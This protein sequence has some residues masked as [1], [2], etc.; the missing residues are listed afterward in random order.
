ML[1]L[2]L[3]L[4]QSVAACCR[5][6]SHE[7]GR[8]QAASASRQVGRQTGLCG[9]SKPSC[10]HSGKALAQTK[11]CRALPLLVVVALCCGC[12]KVSGSAGRGEEKDRASDQ[13]THQ[14]ADTS[15]WPYTRSSYCLLAMRS[16][17]ASE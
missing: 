2:P 3:L 12:G 10:G 17:S 8:P 7:R 14:G 6:K 15:L 5:R 9:T 4:V 1:L 16:W 11:R 13:C